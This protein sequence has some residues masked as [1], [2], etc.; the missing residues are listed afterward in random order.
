M[1]LTIEDKALAMRLAM[2]IDM[3]IIDLSELIKEMEKEKD[4]WLEIMQFWNSIH[5]RSK[6]INLVL[7]RIYL[8]YLYL[9]FS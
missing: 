8:E 7:D 9:K 6:M 3:G 4:S 5:K 2:D 1:S